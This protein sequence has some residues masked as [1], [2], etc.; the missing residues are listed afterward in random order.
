V[1]ASTGPLRGSGFIDIYL[2]FVVLNRFGAQ[3]IQQR[4]NMR[5]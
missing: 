4:K 5:S 2:C 1:D 3:I